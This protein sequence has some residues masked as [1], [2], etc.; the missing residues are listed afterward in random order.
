[1]WFELL[2]PGRCVS[3]LD[4]D[5]AAREHNTRWCTGPATPEYMQHV[6]D[7][8]PKSRA[9]SPTVQ[10]GAMFPV[11]WGDWARSL[12]IY[13][14]IHICFL[15]QVAI[16]ALTPVPRHFGDPRALR[17]HD[18]ET[19][20]G[21]L[22]QLM[23]HIQSHG[24]NA[25]AKVYI[26]LLM[27]AMLFRLPECGNY[28]EIPGITEIQ[29]LEFFCGK[30]GQQGAIQNVLGQCVAKARLT[31]A[32]QTMGCKTRSFDITRSQHA[33]TYICVWNG[34]IVRARLCRAQHVAPAGV[35]A[36]HAER[37]GLN[38]W[39]IVPSGPRLQLLLLD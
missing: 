15:L 29:M 34:V 9:W 22:P 13:I 3:H 28:L 5:H 21:P 39:R 33:L 12:D 2:A 20:L 8:I 23:F 17:P 16:P 14:Y 10:M 24:I 26:D 6:V 32:F 37:P 7:R 11:A 1:M 38:S 36:G 27:S 35:H 31:K 25:H 19:A 30:V 18:D 4:T